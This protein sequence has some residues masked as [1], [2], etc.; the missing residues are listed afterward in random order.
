MINY[1]LFRK[2]IAHNRIPIPIS[3]RVNWGGTGGAICEGFLKLRM[4]KRHQRQII[5]S[6]NSERGV[7]V[8]QYAVWIPGRMT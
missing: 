8:Q 7:G 5:I 6:S 3:N 4:R 1:V 2:T